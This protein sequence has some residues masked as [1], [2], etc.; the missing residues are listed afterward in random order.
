VRKRQ[1]AAI[2]R[3]RLL[4]E[5]KT[6]EKRRA[7]EEFSQTDV[8]RRYVASDAGSVPAT[9]E[10]PYCAEIILAKAT[11]C[12]HCGEFLFGAPRS[13]QSQSVPPNEQSRTIP[14]SGAGKTS[15]VT[16]KN[17]FIGCLVVLIVLLVMGSCVW[18]NA[19][20]GSRSETSPTHYFNSEEDK[21]KFR[22]DN[23]LPPTP[24]DVEQERRNLKEA[25]QKI[26]ESER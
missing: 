22:R 9:Q 6:E 10:C 13:T 17:C 12:K 7:N 24:Y 3:I 19:G 23:N 26:K 8:P 11:K 15:E 18:I 20:S 5:R 21:A 2:E 14:S 25:E 1:D 16:D 4:Q